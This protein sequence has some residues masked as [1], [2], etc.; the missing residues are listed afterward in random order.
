MD[1]Y[2]RLFWYKINGAIDGALI[3]LILFKSSRMYLFVIMVVSSIIK[4]ERTM[5]SAPFIY[6]PFLSNYIPISSISYNG[7]KNK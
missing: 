5:K 2:I 7:G 3:E 6:K 1:I 4:I